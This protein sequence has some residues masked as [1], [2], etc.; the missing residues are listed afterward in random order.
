MDDPR[1]RVVRAGGEAMSKD[2]TTN[3]SAPA[4]LTEAEAWRR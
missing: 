4:L 3:T 1:R 2:T